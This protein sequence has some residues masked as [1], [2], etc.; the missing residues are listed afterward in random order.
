MNIEKEGF[1]DFQRMG[2]NA[3]GAIAHFPT[4]WLRRASLQNVVCI[5]VAPCHQTEKMYT[6]TCPTTVSR[7]NVQNPY[8]R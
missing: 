8:T 2:D 5:V 6:R 7:L 4:R 1:D 3:T